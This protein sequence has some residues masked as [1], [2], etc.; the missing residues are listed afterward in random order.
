M[1]S[2]RLPRE[3]AAFCY[4]RWERC[5]RNIS[6]MKSDFCRSVNREKIMPYLVFPDGRGSTHTICP[7]A[8]VQ[9]PPGYSR[10]DASNTS[11]CESSSF[12]KNDMP[13]DDTLM[14]A[15]SSF[16]S[17]SFLLTRTTGPLTGMRYSERLS[18]IFSMEIFPI[19]A[20]MRE[21]FRTMPVQR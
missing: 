18:S 12:V 14:I 17:E 6:A 19:S 1:K 9:A 5:A 16:F 21:E 7:E 11:P 13:S 15:A 10:N 3:T 8:D 2:S 20:L 4:P